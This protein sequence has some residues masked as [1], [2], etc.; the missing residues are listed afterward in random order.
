M[1][2]PPF[3]ILIY[4][5]LVANST[6]P[7]CPNTKLEPTVWGRCSRAHHNSS[8]VYAE[9]A[10][11]TPVTRRVPT[12][13]SHRKKVAAKPGIRLLGSPVL[14]PRAYTTRAALHDR[15]GQSKWY[16]PHTHSAAEHAGE[17]EEASFYTLSRQF[18]I[19]Y[20]FCKDSLKSCIENLENL[21][22]TLSTASREMISHHRYRLFETSIIDRRFDWKYSNAA[23]QH[24][25]IPGHAQRSGSHRIDLCQ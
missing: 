25:C 14:Y 12:K 24:T 23:M 5:M 22:M 11:R 3:K 19:K 9:S 18:L 21:S 20:Y 13:P 4:L 8:S 10:K 7:S 1:S 16:T 15:N 6:V 2:G 17:R